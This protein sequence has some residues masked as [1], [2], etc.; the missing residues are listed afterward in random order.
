M[1]FRW[2]I[3]RISRSMY[4]QF[5]FKAS[6]SSLIYKH[7]CF[8]ISHP[9][10]SHQHLLNKIK[11]Q[12]SFIIFT[13]LSS[14]FLPF[15]KVKETPLKP[16]GRTCKLICINM[17]TMYLKYQINDIRIWAFGHRMIEQWMRNYIANVLFY[18]TSHSLPVTI[19]IVGK[20]CARR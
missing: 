4:F 10:F 17:S 12:E 14:P 19:D 1:S 3:Y 15:H 16:N 9:T 2:W 11:S 13:P 6:V 5:Q 20:K 8:S 7:I 18:W